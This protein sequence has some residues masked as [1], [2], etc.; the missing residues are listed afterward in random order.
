M[1]SAEE[2]EELQQLA[3]A[4]EVE[5]ANELAHQLA[6]GHML[7]AEE[8]EE[9]EQLAAQQDVEAAAATPRGYEVSLD[10]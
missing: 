9:L 8:Q 4:A 2:Q 10:A 3:E 1:L 5:N 7:M 6:G